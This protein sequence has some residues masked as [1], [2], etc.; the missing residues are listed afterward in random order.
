MT[1]SSMMENKSILFHPHSTYRFLPYC[2][3]LHPSPQES[4]PSYRTTNAASASAT[5]PSGS[6]ERAEWQ[7][8]DVAH[9]ECM[10]TP[11]IHHGL[12]RNSRSMVVASPTHEHRTTLQDSTVGD[13]I[14]NNFALLGI[15]MSPNQRTKSTAPLSLFICSNSTEPQ[16]INRAHRNKAQPQD[17]PAIS[18]ALV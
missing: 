9:E 7:R 13:P 1:D 18:L 12:M 14:I 15:E 4:R 11:W 6:G 8:R 17:P 2:Q 5:D 3:S 16:T 10:C